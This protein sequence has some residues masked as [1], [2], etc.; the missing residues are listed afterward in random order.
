MRELR[1]NF[2]LNNMGFGLTETYLE[3]GKKPTLTRNVNGEVASEFLL[4]N[5][6]L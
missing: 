5:L 3:L 6:L 1:F 2:D 4:S